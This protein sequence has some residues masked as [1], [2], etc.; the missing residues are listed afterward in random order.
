MYSTELDMKGVSKV[1]AY[2]ENSFGLSLKAT[3]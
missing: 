3:L 2:G 1:N